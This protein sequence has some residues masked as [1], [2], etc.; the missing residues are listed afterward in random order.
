MSDSEIRAFLEESHTLM[1]ATLG[2]DGFPHVVPM[3]YFVLDGKVAFRSFTKSQK[4]VNLRRD[5]RLTVLAEAGSRY[6]GLRGVMIKGKA[7][8][9]EDADTILD[10]YGEISGRY[11]HADGPAHRLTGEALQQAYGRFA[12]KNTGI[13]VE[14]I[15]VISWDHRKLGGAY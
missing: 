8:F 2:P 9:V 10:W 5:P 14:P 1:V 15:E 3:W 12:P 13:V 7:R 4:I 6:A 11:P